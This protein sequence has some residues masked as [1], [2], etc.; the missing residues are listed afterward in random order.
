MVFDTA[1]CGVRVMIGWNT[2]HGWLFS[3]LRL[4]CQVNS[5]VSPSAFV[6]KHRGWLHRVTVFGRYTQAA[7][8]RVYP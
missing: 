4:E 2:R 6:E 7:S 8:V 1:P 3:G 5:L